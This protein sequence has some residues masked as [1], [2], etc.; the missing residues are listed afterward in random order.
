MKVR[1]Y[2]TEQLSSFSFFIKNNDSQFWKAVKL[3]FISKIH[4]I[5]RDANLYNPYV[6]PIVE[7]LHLLSAA[8]GYLTTMDY[9]KSSS[10]S[11]KTTSSPSRQSQ[12][13]L[14]KFTKCRYKITYI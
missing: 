5:C 1:A 11:S 13:Q 14:D 7:K 12:L 4:D 3:N 2:G 9:T 6:Q 10:A 8:N